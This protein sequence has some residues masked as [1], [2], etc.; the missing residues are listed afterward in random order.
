MG[1]IDLL[2]ILPSYLGFSNLSGLKVL[3]VIR[4]L[5]LLKLSKGISKGLKSREENTEFNN[6]KMSLQIYLVAL[7]YVVIVFSTLMFYAEKNVERNILHQYSSSN[8]VVHD[9]NCHCRI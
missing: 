8:V 2:V 1:I 7:F 9:N 5:R 3:R 6:F 4:I